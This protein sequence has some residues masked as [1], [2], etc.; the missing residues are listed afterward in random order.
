M[1]EIAIHC[2]LVKFC[3]IDN[4]MQLQYSVFRVRL[5]TDKFPVQCKSALVLL[6]CT[7]GSTALPPDKIHDFIKL[8]FKNEINKIP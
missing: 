1:Y 2:T 8:K 4:C 3:A 7:G 6:Y 5:K